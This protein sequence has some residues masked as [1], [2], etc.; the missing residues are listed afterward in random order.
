MPGLGSPVKWGSMNTSDPMPMMTAPWER[1]G[2]RGT[3]G[4]GLSRSIITLLDGCRL[5]HLM[6]VSAVAV[7]DVA[8]VLAV[9]VAVL[10]DIG[11]DSDSVS[12]G[13]SALLS[14]VC[15]SEYSPVMALF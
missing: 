10:T 7:A 1:K 12:C 2:R 5:W 14:S 9:V 13:M 8:V 4:S 15:A 11:S 3:F 6:T